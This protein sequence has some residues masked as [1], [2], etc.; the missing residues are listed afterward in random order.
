MTLQSLLH[1]DS[2][3]PWRAAVIDLDGTLLN[4]QGNI[5]DRS[6][7]VLELLHRRNMVIVIAT[8]RLDADARRILQKI[9]F[10]PTVVSCNGVLIKTD[11]LLP[12]MWEQTLT[13]A[14]SEQILRF[15][16]RRPLHVTLFSH[17]GWH[18]VRRNPYLADD[19]ARSGITCH[20]H[21]ERE[22]HNIAS[23]KILLH[24]ADAEIDTAFGTLRERFGADTA[25]SKSSRSTIDIVS[26]GQNK[27]TAVKR[28]LASQHIALA[29]TIAFG[30]AMNDLE[31]LSSVGHGVLMG[32]AMHELQRHLPNLPQALPNHQDGVAH[33]LEQLLLL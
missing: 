19:I 29:Q 26:R 14:V 21:S 9:D 10:T 12:P 18:C 25:L 28:F 22:I 16:R 4:H 31:L 8:G 23:L 30:D 2:P 5:S 7:K 27:M 3:K 1:T 13:P 32:N 15:T 11:P 20:Y 24:G 33:Y 17:S 6:I